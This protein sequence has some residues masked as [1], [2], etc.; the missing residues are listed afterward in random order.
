[1]LH[2]TLQN[3]IPPADPDA[4]TAAIEEAAIAVEFGERH[5]QMLA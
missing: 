5:R 2:R 4:D 3:P 1:M